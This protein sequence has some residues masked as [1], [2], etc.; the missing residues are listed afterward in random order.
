[1][2]RGCKAA[3]L[4]SDRTKR[5]NFMNAAYKSPDW[6]PCIPHDDAAAASKPGQ[7]VHEVMTQAA[8]ATT[9]AQIELLFRHRGQDLVK[10]MTELERNAP[11]RPSK[12]A[13]LE[14]DLRR[15]GVRQAVLENLTLAQL[16][17]RRGSMIFEHIAHRH[18]NEALPDAARDEMHACFMAQWEHFFGLTFLAFIAVG[19]I[20]DDAPGVDLVLPWFRTHSREVYVHAVLAEEALKAAA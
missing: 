8:A 15:R 9:I 2:T 3:I 20:R 5:P 14:A 10:A 18:K 17:F 11:A 16:S 7:L 4:A 13:N 19:A 6:D 12:R 1:M